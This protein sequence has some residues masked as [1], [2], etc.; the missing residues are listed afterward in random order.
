M[1]HIQKMLLITL[2]ALPTI[3]FANANLL[4]GSWKTIDDR[5]GYVLTD[6]EI[7]QNKKGLYEGT[8]IKLYPIPGTP[9][10]EICTQ[11]TG[12]FK[13]KAY[14]GTVFMWGFKQNK[15]N[16]I[17]FLDGTIIDPVNG[18]VYSAKIKLNSTGNR[19]TLRGYLN[20]SQIG[21]S[22]TWIKNTNAK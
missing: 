9:L 6:V 4:I 11:C 17:E 15:Q 22:A 5:T 20:H 13:N 21:R 14:R 7:R 12:K 8:I 2:L 18:K 10:K 19:L 1:L 3:I 16:P